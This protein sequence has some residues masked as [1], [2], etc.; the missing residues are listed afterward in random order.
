MPVWMPEGAAGRGE[1]KPRALQSGSCLLFCDTLLPCKQRTPWGWAM[2]TGTAGNGVGRGSDERLAIR[3]LTSPVSNLLSRNKE[4]FV[5]RA[6]A[7]RPRAGLG[8][9]PGGGKAPPP[10]SW[11]WCGAIWHARLACIASLG[12]MRS[13]D[14][15]QAPTRCSKEEER[16]GRADISSTRQAGSNAYAL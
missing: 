12:K 11:V 2:R 9:S 13:L 15:A 1:V 4:F 8:I 14:G 7:V 6:V 10:G 16:F 3:Q 5:V